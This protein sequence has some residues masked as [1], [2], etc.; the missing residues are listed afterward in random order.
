ALILLKEPVLSAEERK[1]HRNRF[2]FKDLQEI[3]LRPQT[4]LAILLFFLVTTGFSQLEATF[5]LFVLARY[6]L[7]AQHAGFILALMALVMVFIQGGAIGRLVQKF[8]EPKL[9]LMGSALMTFALLTSSLVAPLSLFVSA[10]L[11][12][13]LGY[14]MTNPALSSLTSRNAPTGFQGATL[15]IYQSAGSL[16][17]MIGPLTAGF[18]FDHY[19]SKYPLWSASF[20]FLMCALLMGSFSQTWNVENQKMD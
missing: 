10:L 5:A 11:V 19:G 1:N 3:L 15:G 8:G 20:L 2:T 16:G 4:G 14:A 13:A 18:L 9:I 17:R 7:D 6:G 12:Q